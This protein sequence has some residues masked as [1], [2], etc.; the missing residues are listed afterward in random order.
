M[1]VDIS[2]PS[3]CVG[4]GGIISEVDKRVMKL[5]CELNKRILGVDTY[6]VTGEKWH[7]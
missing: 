3:L 6:A 4:V 1:S 2:T 5:L 7:P